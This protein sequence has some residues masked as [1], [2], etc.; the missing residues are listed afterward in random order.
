M[1]KM[2]I[3]GL[4]LSVFAAGLVPLSPC[5]MLSS[6]MAECAEATTQSLCNQMHPQSVGT[7]TFK[8]SDKSCCVTSQAPLPEL[9]FNSIEVGPVVTISVS[10]STLAIP[11]ARPSSTLSFF[12]YSSPPSFQSLLCTFL[13]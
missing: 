7:Q 1:R 12:E 5:A 11:S 13:I 6:K 3:L 9:Q 8:G 2:L 4:S 10:Q